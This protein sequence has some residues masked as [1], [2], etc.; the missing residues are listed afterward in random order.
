MER[1]AD[2]HRNGK[3][4]RS[5]VGCP[6]GGGAGVHGEGPTNCS[7]AAVSAPLAMQ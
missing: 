5:F 1:A 6:W 7:E 3:L 4:S 2:L